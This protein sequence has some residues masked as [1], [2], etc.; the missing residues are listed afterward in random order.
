[1]V[2]KSKMEYIID[3]LM[4]AEKFRHKKY[5]IDFSYNGNVKEIDFRIANKRTYKG[6][7]MFYFYIDR[8]STY[9]IAKVVT[10]IKNTADML[11]KGSQ[12]KKV[13]TAL[14]IDDV[15]YADID[16]LLAGDEENEEVYL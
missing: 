11:Q 2:L 1:M 8:L 9:E 16:E 3:L 5:Y 7:I 13:K 14:P 15:G 6:E 12:I 4:S 10:E